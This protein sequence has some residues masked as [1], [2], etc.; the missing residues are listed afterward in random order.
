MSNIEMKNE[1]LKDDDFTFPDEI[2]KMRME[3]S[4]KLDEIHESRE[5]HR[6]SL[7]INNDFDNSSFKNF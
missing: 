5:E 1:F 7:G 4:E 2:E 6:R 3:I